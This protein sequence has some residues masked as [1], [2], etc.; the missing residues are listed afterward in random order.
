[1]GATNNNEYAENIIGY[2]DAMAD[3]YT[4]ITETARYGIPRW[5]E[6]RLGVSTP[7]SP[8]VLDLG[9]AN[10][11]LG[12]IVKKNFPDC[13]M[14][15]VDI[16]P[17]MIDELKKTGVYDDAQVWDLSLGLPFVK[18]DA[19]DI[20]LAIGFLEFLK[21][22]K[23]LLS[24][25]SFSMKSAG[26]CLASF[27]VYD[28]KKH[29]SRIVDNPGAGFPRYLYNLEDIDSLA[30][31]SNLRINSCENITAYISPT[32]GELREYCVLSLSR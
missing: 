9:C 29:A 18:K 1:M 28:M 32:T 6:S 31:A 5:L 25:V 21:Q 14:T 11:V 2:Y 16:S 23:I 12:A 7:A 10:G 27:E 17:K 22:P 30:K 19:F 3:K 13:R 4:Q 15:G 24:G 26:Q 20:V 8:S